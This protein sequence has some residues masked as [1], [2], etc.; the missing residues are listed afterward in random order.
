MGGHQAW[1]G[2]VLGAETEAGFIR[3]QFGKILLSTGSHLETTRENGGFS[4]IRDFGVK[5][6]QSIIVTS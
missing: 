4:F 6:R 5:K 2:S 3:M 1:Q